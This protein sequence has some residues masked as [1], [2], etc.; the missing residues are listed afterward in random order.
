MT[1]ASSQGGVSAVEVTA[2]GRGVVRVFLGVGVLNLAACLGVCLA[3]GLPTPA[4]ITCAG[5]FV[6][7]LSAAAVFLR[8]S[9]P[10]A[11]LGLANVITLARLSMVTVLLG[12]LIAGGAEPWFVIALGVVALSLD[13]VDG[14]AA[15]KQGLASRFGASFDM[16]VDSAF[17]LV[18]SLLAATGP[19]GPIAILL[20]LPRYLYG[21]AAVALPWLNGELAPRFSRKVVCVVQL[22][23]LI[24]LQLPFLGMP[25]A[26]AIVIV[27]AGALAWSFGIDTVAL[28]RGRRQSAS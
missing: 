13:G 15:R 16:E 1:A 26:L 23:A 14:Y 9:H 22:V 27:T 6:V 12:I 2:G 8:R 5:A 18:L 11:R 21:L 20:G 24:A 17:A 7:A 4:L 28:H 25:V 3:L 10:H 19:A